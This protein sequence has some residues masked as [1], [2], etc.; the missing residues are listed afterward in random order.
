ML[1][2]NSIESESIKFQPKFGTFLQHNESNELND[3]ATTLI[4]YLY[5]LITDTENREIL[6]NH[7]SNLDE[8]IPT[9]RQ[10]FLSIP[11]SR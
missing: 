2:V 3:N 1:I 8:N 4:A 6:L 11:V 9:K 10:K 7:T 5:S